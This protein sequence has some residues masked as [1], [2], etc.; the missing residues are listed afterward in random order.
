MRF[1]RQKK[2]KVWILF[3]SFSL[4]CVFGSIYYVYFYTPKNSLELYQAISFADNF[5]DVQKLILEDYEDNFKKEDF[6]YMNRLDTNA[7]NVSQFALFE[8]DEKTFV[9]M[10]SPRTSKLKILAVEEL[11]IGIRNYFIILVD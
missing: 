1:Q 11:P 7:N 2:L 8:Y 4:M 3:I 6:T 10:T 9:I 5:E